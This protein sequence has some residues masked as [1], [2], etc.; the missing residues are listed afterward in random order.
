MFLSNL[1]ITRPVFAAVLMLSLLTLGIAS[2]RRLAIDLYPNVEIPVITVVTIYPGASPETV[3]RDVT[4]K[5]EEAIN[6]IAGLR[7][8]GSNSREGVSQLFA[9]FQL[10]VSADRAAEDA[11]TK[12]A[13]IRGDLPASIQDPI[14]QRLDI[15]GMPIVSLA[16]RSDTLPPR[17]LT[18]LVEKKIARRLENVAGVGKVDRIGAIERE[19]SIA[20]KPEQLES[21]GLGI[22]EVVLGLARENVDAPLGRLT[23]P[24]S[25]APLRVQGKARSIDDFRAMVIAARGGRPI[26]LGEVAEVAD[27]EEEARSLAFVDGTPAV[28]LD[29]LKQSGANAVAV[30]DAIRAEAARLTNEL[31]PG[32]H[33]NLNPR[34]SRELRPRPQ[35]GS[36]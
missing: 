13:A 21:L 17:E 23:G 2:Y 16:V 6:P 20:V 11:R 34:R 5:I 12:I 33:S 7:H 36:H 3:E 18:T 24:S 9:E 10:E 1:S 31:P 22:D 29:V 15:A 30:A 25:E 14:I 4:K 28:A 19:V 26:T 8:V 27:G 32:R 35:D